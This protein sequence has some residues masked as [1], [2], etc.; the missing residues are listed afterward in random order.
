MLIISVLVAEASQLTSQTKKYSKDLINEF[1]EKREITR[2]QR[3]KEYLCETIK[4]PKE[5]LGKQNELPP[6]LQMYDPQKFLSSYK[7]LKFYGD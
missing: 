6:S 1:M 2:K 7:D 5:L 4:Y 3:I